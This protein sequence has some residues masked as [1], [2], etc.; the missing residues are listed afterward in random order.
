[1]DKY[2]WKKVAN[3]YQPVGS[4]V[5]CSPP[6]M[7]TDE[8]WLI[9]DPDCDVAVFLDDL[10]WSGCGEDYDDDDTKDMSVFRF[11]DVNI[12]CMH[13]DD[14]YDKFILATKI[15]KGLNLMDKSDRVNLF[16]AIRYGRGF[17]SM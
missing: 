12:I 10:G 16:E 1:M 17:A 13:C 5:T 4:R 9:Y 3:K 6:P 8:D 2:A 7:D 14:Q 15:S 11:E